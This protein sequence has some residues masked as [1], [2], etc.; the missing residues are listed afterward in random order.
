MEL[1]EYLKQ[2][3]QIYVKLFYMPAIV[4]LKFSP[5]I[6]DFA[7]RLSR[8]GKAKMVIVIA[9]MRKLLHIIYGVLKTKTSINANIQAIKSM[10]LI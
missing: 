4:S 10:E 5:I 2:V 8:K 6:K 3:I 7:E 1:V 9:A